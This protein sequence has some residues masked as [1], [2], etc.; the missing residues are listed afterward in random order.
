MVLWIVKILQIRWVVNV[1]NF[2]CKIK[3]QIWDKNKIKD[4][5]NVQKKERVENSLERLMRGEHREI[6]EYSFDKIE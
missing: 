4:S 5:T 3:E 1:K 6:I 2:K